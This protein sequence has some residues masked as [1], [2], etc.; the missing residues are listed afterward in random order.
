[1]TEATPVKLPLIG[2]QPVLQGGNHAGDDQ[3]PG[4]LQGKWVIFSPHPAD[5]TPVCT[6]EFM[7]SPPWCRN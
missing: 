1:M 2:E 4:R 3:L 5:F 6:T 7:T